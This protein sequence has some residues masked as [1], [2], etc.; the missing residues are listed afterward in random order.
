MPLEIELK[1]RLPQPHNA[2]E[3]LKTL[4]ATWRGRV[5]EHNQIFDT[6]DHKLRAAGCGLRIRA[7]VPLDPNVQSSAT[8]IL[9]F[10]GPRRAG[11][12]KIREEIETEIRDA[13]ALRTILNRLGFHEVIGYEKRR[14]SWSLARCE[15]T[16]DELPRLGW[17]AE[18]EAPDPNAIP[19]VRGQLGLEQAEVVQ[20][21]Y[22]ELAAQH[23]EKGDDGA[24]RLSF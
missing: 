12:L 23:G 4:G 2:R 21:S 15:I 6:P 8:S 20:E 5:L 9:T 7:A 19:V 11:E 24:I 3:R 22:V 14:E 13:A 17:F 1:V 16:L 18:I 10:K